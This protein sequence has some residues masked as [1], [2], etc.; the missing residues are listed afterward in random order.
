MEEHKKNTFRKVCSFLKDIWF[1]VLILGL[2][3]FACLFGELIATHS[4]TQG[5]LSEYLIPPAWCEGGSMEHLLGTDGLGRDIFS[6]LVT[7]AR[8]TMMVGIA[9]VLVAGSIGTLVGVLAGYMGGAVDSLLMRL[10]DAVLSIP[11]TLIAMCLS[12]IL[13]QSSGTVVFVL[14]ITCWSKYAKVVRVETMSLK[15]QEFVTLAKLAG[16]SRIRILCR[17]ILPNLLNTIIVMATLQLGMA[18]ILSSSLS[19][20]G[21]GATP[22]TPEWGL[23][24]SEGRDYMTSGAWWLT[25]IP[26]IALFLTVLSVNILGNVLRVKLDPKRMVAM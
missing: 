8:T 14:G 13:G 22:P 4:P 7:G 1:P 25:T 3:V 17:H 24:M 5:Q 9:V 15:Q 12:V 26:G 18:I 10:T 11:Y 19:F 23:M 2:V 21:L 16:A 6:R 20:L